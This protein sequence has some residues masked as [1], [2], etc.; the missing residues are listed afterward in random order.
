ACEKLCECHGL[1]L[2]KE[3]VRKLM[4]D[5][6]LWIPRRQRPPKV[7]QPRPRRFEWGRPSHCFSTHRKLIG[8]YGNPAS[9][10]AMAATDRITMTMHDP[11]RF[12]V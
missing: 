7:Y 1:Q 6:G 11:D 9:E 2:S 10:V 5:A 12:K 8:R 3:T 4:T